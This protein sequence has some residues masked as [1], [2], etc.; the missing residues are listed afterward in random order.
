MPAHRKNYDEAVKMYRSGMS[1]GQVA[2]F[3]NISRQAMHKILARR[4]VV[5]RPQKR[6]Q[7]DNHFYRDGSR[8]SKRVHAIMILALE[9]GILVPGPCE[10]CGFFGQ[11]KDGRC[12]V[13]GHHDD[14]NKPLE[15]RWLCKNHHH[16]WHKTNKAIPLKKKLPV[17]SRKELCSMGGKA[18]WANT[19][20]IDRTKKLAKMR[21]AKKRK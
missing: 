10:K 12:L 15:V 21:K 7:E 20:K 13:H 18:S 14:Y 3:Y 8:A 11:A 1:I 19:S 6:Y 9:K 5:F 17:M 4:N 16:E 2:E